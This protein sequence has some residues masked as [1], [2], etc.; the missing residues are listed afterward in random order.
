MRPQPPAG[1][2]S[3]PSPRRSGLDSGAVRRTLA[4]LSFGDGPF[5]GSGA[6][7]ASSFA[8]THACSIWAFVGLGRIGRTPASSAARLLPIGVFHEGRYPRLP[9]VG[10]SQG[11]VRHLAD[12]APL[13]SLA[14]SFQQNEILSM[15]PVDRTDRSSAERHRE[16]EPDRPPRRYRTPL[17]SAPGR[18]LLLGTQSRKEKRKRNHCRL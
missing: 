18:V 14:C 12:H 10:T 17:W 1:P 4:A 6:V 8:E 9:S 5:L 15:A 3:A 7:L 16:Q 13:D 2:G 11:D